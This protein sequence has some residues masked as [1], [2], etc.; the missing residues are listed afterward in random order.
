MLKLIL[1][2]LVVTI[3]TEE[4]TLLVCKC[5]QISIYIVCL[6]MNIIT[7][8]SLNFLIQIIP[9]YYLGL[10]L[11]ELSVFVI[12]SIVYFLFTKSFK[13]AILYSLLCNL[14]SLIIGGFI[15]Y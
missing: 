11:L 14:V 13:K 12:E 3:I 5:K 1:I 7:N 9:N 10:I 2:P 4:L 8:V 15:R 6:V